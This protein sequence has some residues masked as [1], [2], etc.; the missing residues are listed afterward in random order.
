M[1]NYLI[2]PS[3]L[4]SFSYYMSEY[5]K[6]EDFLKTLSREKFEPNE[7]MQ[8]GIEFEDDINFAC[9]H[10]IESPKQ[11]LAQYCNIVNEISDIVQGGVWQAKVQKALK[12]GDTEYLVYGICDNIKK[13]TI[14]D[15]KY[16]KNYEL[17]KYSNSIQHPIYMY[18]TG[19]SKF[20]YLISDGKEWWREDYQATKDIENDIKSRITE[21]R[22]YLAGDKEAENLFLTKWKS[23]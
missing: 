12:I 2:T 4:N 6:R 5:G 15:I 7:A 8:K 16:T 11:E 17:G 14:Y 18:C 20:A 3:L 23:Q 13:D 10:G 19:L 9:K 21:F 1:E 22:N